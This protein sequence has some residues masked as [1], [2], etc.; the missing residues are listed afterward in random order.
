[1]LGIDRRVR[2]R[3]QFFS[4]QPIPCRGLQLVGQ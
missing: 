4:V 2:N 1:M 3:A